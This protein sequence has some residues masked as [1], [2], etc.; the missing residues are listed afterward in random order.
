VFPPEQSRQGAERS[1]IHHAPEYGS[2][3][4]VAEIEPA[5]LFLSR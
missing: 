5:G 3:L 4:N 1:E 2:R